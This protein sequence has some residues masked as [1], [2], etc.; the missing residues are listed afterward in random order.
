MNN[1]LAKQ[2]ID[3]LTTNKFTSSDLIFDEIRPN[4]YKFIVDVYNKT[5]TPLQKIWIH[6]PKVRTCFDTINTNNDS[7]PLSVTLGPL[8]DTLNDIYNLIKLIEKTVKKKNLSSNFKS[9]IKKV[10]DF[11]PKFNCSIP[12]KNNKWDIPVYDHNHK[13]VNINNLNRGDYVSM[14]IELSHVWIN[15][16]NFGCSWTVKQLKIY[17]IIDFSVCLFI[18][19]TPVDPEPIS[20]PSIKQNETNIINIPPPTIKYPC[21]PS[22]PPIP[23]LS[24]NKPLI[25]MPRLAISPESLL[26]QKNN[27]KSTIKNNDIKSPK[28]N[29]DE[30][31][32]IKNNFTKKK[33]NNYQS[34]MRMIKI[35]TMENKRNQKLL[36][37]KYNEILNDWNLIH[38]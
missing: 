32:L 15:D 29:N 38:K 22:I 13:L 19:E 33:N 23:N 7:T 37:L 14:F 10:P 3:K 26:A 16:W 11:F 20:K 35:E 25:S 18:N 9:S 24:I 17:P 27:L 21:V 34:Q 30:K 36:E 28:K 2:T 31:S 6:I 5:K 12:I 4:N 1:E 8:K